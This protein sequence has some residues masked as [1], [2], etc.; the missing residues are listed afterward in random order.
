MEYYNWL[1]TEQHMEPESALTTAAFRAGVPRFEL[2][3]N[4]R[5]VRV[6]DDEAS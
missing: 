3:L 4:V 2:A 6:Y 5:E 1:V